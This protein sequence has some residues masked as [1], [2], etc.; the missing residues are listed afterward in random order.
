M[1]GG[2]IGVAVLIGDVWAIIN[3]LRSRVSPGT[4]LLWTLLIL[5]L[6]VVGLVIWLFAGPRG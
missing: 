3:V 2:L 1:T 5:F 6:P 4:K